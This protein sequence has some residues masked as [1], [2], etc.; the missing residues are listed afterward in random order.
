MRHLLT[1]LG[2][3]FIAALFSLLALVSVGFMVLS[4]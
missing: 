4:P 2:I 1:A 3:A